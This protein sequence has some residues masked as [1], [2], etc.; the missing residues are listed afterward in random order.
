MP[1][2]YM[3][4]S[5]PSLIWDGASEFRVMSVLIAADLYLRTNELYTHHSMLDRQTVGFSE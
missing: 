2:P 4:M 1:Y 5:K 3:M